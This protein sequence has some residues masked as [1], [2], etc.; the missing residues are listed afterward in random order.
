MMNTRRDFLKTA[1][2]G[3]GA[4]ML[5]PYLSKASAAPQRAPTGKPPMRFIFMHK[6]NGLF[7]SVMVP[8][9]LSQQDMAKENK[10]EPFEVDLDKHE[11]PGWMSAL[12]DHKK[13]HDDPAGIVG[14]DVH[15]RASLVAVMS[16][17]LRGQ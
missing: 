11:L 16:R 15:Q 5:S 13:A 3:T 1:A 4:A 7:P 9:S 12:N 17:R 10:K 2:L 6:G 8:P 14:Q